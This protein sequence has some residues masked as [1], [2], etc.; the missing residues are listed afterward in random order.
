M[1]KTFHHAR[2]ALILEF[3]IFTL[4][5]LLII[6]ICVHVVLIGG[7]GWELIPMDI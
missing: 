6:Q 1:K 2:T 7:M 5:N 4:E 3:K